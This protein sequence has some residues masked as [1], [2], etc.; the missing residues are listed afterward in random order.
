LS[1]DTIPDYIE[2]RIR[3]PA[4][5]GVRV[6]EGSTPVVAFGDV[7]KARV[8]TLGWNPSKAEF[9]DGDGR[10]LVGDSRRL[11]TLT[12]LNCQDLTTA[13]RATV[14]RV[15]RG[16]N[17]YF[18]RHPYHRWFDRLD[19]VLKCADYS[20]YD[21]S[22]CHLDLVQW[23]TDPVWSR[24]NRSEKEALL[25]ADLPMLFRQLELEHIRL[26]LLNGKGI[27]RA[28]R[29][30]VALALEEAPARRGRVEIYAGR[31]PRGLLVV[32]WNINLQGS[33][34]V[35]NHEIAEIGAKVADIVG[36]NL[37]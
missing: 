14:A 34:G 26:L 32:G 22:A 27:V 8:A 3:R 18:S 30:R 31:S 36:A 24:L 17:S 33:F 25:R 19:K 1:T 11:E 21:G 6:V 29:E 5:D 9:R 35:S 12:S 2:A 13:P 7:R 4:P 15:F 37:R 10:E 28:Y 16:C 23:A 20:F